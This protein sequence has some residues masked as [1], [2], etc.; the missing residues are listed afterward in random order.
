MGINGTVKVLDWMKA[1]GEMLDA[2][3]VGEPTSAK[4][5]GDEIKIGRRGYM[6]AEVTVHGKQGHSAYAAPGRQPDP[7]ARAHSRPRVVDADGSGARRASSRPACRPTLISVP[8]TATNVIPGAARANFNIRYNDL[9]TRSGVE[10]WVRAALRGG[11]RRGGSPALA[12]LLRHGRR[13]PDR[14]GSAGR[15]HARGGDAR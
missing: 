12:A 10:A 8:N 5:L 2:C 6:N 9:H 3:L 1:R 13:V 4:M 7:Q 11:G 15:H 14:A